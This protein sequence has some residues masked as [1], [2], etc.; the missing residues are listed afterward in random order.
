[1][2]LDVAIV[3]FNLSVWHPKPCELGQNDVEPFVHEV[4]KNIDT[5][6][7]GHANH[8]LFHLFLNALFNESL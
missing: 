4:G 3:H 6:P 1:M 2:V 8:D 7:V 5:P